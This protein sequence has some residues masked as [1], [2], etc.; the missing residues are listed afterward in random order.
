NFYKV[1][2]R[3]SR[4]LSEKFRKNYKFWRLKEIDNSNSGNSKCETL[5]PIEEDQTQ[6][7]LDYREKIISEVD[8]YTDGKFEAREDFYRIK[9]FPKKEELLSNSESRIRF[10]NIMLNKGIEILAKTST[11]IPNM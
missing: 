5:V 11:H 2:K 4:E 10:E 3:F 9:S 6:E 7:V 8:E 1:N